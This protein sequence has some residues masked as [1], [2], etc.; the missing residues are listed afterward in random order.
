MAQ[1]PVEPD[2][3][4]TGHGRP[5]RG[6]SLRRGLVELA[7]RF[8]GVAVPQHG[9]YAERPLSADDGSAYRER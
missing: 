2:A 8:R 1:I 6:E 4:V 5:M 9:V 3:A 7:R